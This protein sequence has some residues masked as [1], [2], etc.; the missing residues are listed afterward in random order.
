MRVPR[1]VR[2]IGGRAFAPDWPERKRRNQAASNYSRVALKVHSPTRASHRPSVPVGTMAFAVSASAV[3]RVA[4]LG[5][6]SSLR[7]STPSG[8]RSTGRGGVVTTQAFF[9]FG[10]VKQ[11]AGVAMVCRDC[12]YVYRGMDFNDLPRDYK[13]PPCGSREERVPPGEE[14]GFREGRV[15]RARARARRSGR[16]KRRSARSAPRRG[17]RRRWRRRRGAERRVR[18][19]SARATGGAGR[20]A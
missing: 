15:Q 8:P 20:R 3:G 7:A 2:A 13:C 9:N 19:T 10:G 4:F 6:N 1:R 5:A 17:R 11:P 16:T 12:G 14:G 18:L